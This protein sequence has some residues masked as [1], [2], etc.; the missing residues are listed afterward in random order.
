MFWGV[1]AF[2]AIGYIANLMQADSIQIAQSQL[3][4]KHNN[5]LGE[6]TKAL[7]KINAQLSLT[8]RSLKQLDRKNQLILSRLKQVENDLIQRDRQ[9]AIL[10]TKLTKLEE[11]IGSITGALQKEQTSQKLSEKSVETQRIGDVD[12]PIKKSNQPEPPLNK[13]S[14]LEVEDE[15]SNKKPNLQKTNFAITLGAY[16]NLKNLKRAW[17]DIRKKHKNELA[18][19]NPRFI[20]IK[21]KNKTQYE[22]ISGPLKNVLDAAKLCY[23]LNKAKTYCKHAIYQGKKI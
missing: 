7:D 13:L 15:A 11:S 6:E 9:N 23:R 10:K 22:L 20:Q 5:K 1:L 12:L 14:M 17:K 18:E 8:R 19:L 2:A 4:K 21:H 16:S 3:N